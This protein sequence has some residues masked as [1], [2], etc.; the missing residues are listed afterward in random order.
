MSPPSI[1]ECN[2]ALESGAAEEALRLAIELLHRNKN[3]ID[4]LTVCYR[5]YR[6]KKDLANSASVLE[7]ILNVDPLIDWAAAELGNL[8]F[9]SGRID[10]AEAVLRRAVELHPDSAAANAHLGKVFSELNRL[11]AGE[12][13]FRRALDVGGPDCNTLTDLALN[14]TRQERADEAG[15]LYRQAHELEPANIHTIAYWAKLHEVRGE[16]DEAKALLDKAMA[17]QPGSV[18]L[19]VATLQARAGDNEGA[20]ATIDRGRKLNGDA[21]LERGLIKDR[22]GDFDGAW[23]DFVEAKRSLAIEAGGLRYDAGAVEKF[24]GELRETFDSNTMRLLPKAAHRAGTAQPLFIVGA[25]RSGTTLVERILASH[26]SIAAGGELPFIQDMRVFSEKLLPEA[27]FPKNVAAACVA[28]RRHVVTLFRDFYLAQRDERFEPACGTE[29]VTDKMPFNEMYLPLIRLA[30]PECPVVH[31]SRHRLDVAISMF[32]NKLNHGFHCAYRIKDILH[33]LNAV[34][35]LHEQYRQQFDTREF[36]VHYEK[37]ASEPESTVRELLDYIGLP[38]EER[39]LRFHEERRFVATPSYRQV[40]S[41][42]SNR[43]VGRHRN[44]Q[45][46]FDKILPPE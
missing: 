18:D 16:V 35:E 4:A 8:Y 11:S 44:Y 34:A 36:V 30:F 19:L 37:L 25:P 39:C 46:Q 9:L 41:K 15:E 17:V 45:R 6:L 3:D 42:I 14:L 7:V 10:K 2:R 13:H 12:W 23:E 43:S 28:D 38:F 21:L 5:A 33:H 26:P 1:K 24:F 29:F 22:I 31:V 20:L 40:D 32:S 27:G